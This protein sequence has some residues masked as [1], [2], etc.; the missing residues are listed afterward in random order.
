MTPI[1]FLKMQ[2][3]NKFAYQTSI[4]RSQMKWSL[5]RK[6]HALTYTAS[7]KTCHDVF[8]ANFS[9]YDEPWSKTVNDNDHELAFDLEFQ[10]IVVKNDI[11]VIKGGMSAVVLTYDRS[12]KLTGKKLL[13]GICPAQHGFKGFALTLL[14]DRQILLTGGRREY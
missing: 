9:S 2:G 14:N 11:Y 1:E 6:L 8:I 4:S 13:A 10:T 12:L 7:S 3:L 5:F